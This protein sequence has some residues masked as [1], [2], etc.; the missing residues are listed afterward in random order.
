MRFRIALLAI[1]ILIS[2]PSLAQDDTE[3]YGEFKVWVESSAFEIREYS[4]EAFRANLAPIEEMI[5]DSRVVGLSESLHS[6]AEPVAFRNMLFKFLVEELGFKAIVIESGIAESKALNDYAIGLENDIEASLL[7]GL[8]NRF[9]L[10]QGNRSLLQWIRS[11]NDSLAEEE[12]KVQIFGM[13]VSGSPP[14]LIATRKPDAPLNDTLDYL[15][16]V[17][18]ISSEEYRKRIGPLLPS[19]ASGNGYGMLTQGERDG[20]TASIEDIISLIKRKKLEYIE[21]STEYE[22]AWAERIAVASRQTDSWFRRMPLEWTP[23]GEYD[24]T[25]ESQNI[26]DQV[27][28]E[29]LDWVLDQLNGDDRVLVFASINHIAKEQHEWPL[30]LIDQGQRQY[31]RTPL[32]FYA[33]TQYGSDYINIFNIVGDGEMKPCFQP[34]ASAIIMETPRNDWIDFMFHGHSMSEYFID[35]RSAPKRLLSWMSEIREQR[36]ARISALGSFDLAYYVDGFTDDCI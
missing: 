5:G 29:N 22:Y 16:K 2:H 32:G 17:D 6:V 25:V 1:G 28:A 14:G 13:D 10:F 3:I 34:Q 26:R 33:M 31:K 23:S 11:H 9:D 4:Q 21:E 18:V 24:W 12:N 8:S 27:M 35:L 20:L 7:N 15:Q 30:Y 19:L 36:N